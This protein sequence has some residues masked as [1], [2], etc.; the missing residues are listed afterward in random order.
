MATNFKRVIYIDEKVIKPK[1]KVGSA[2]ITGNASSAVPKRSSDQK[3][4][5]GRP[6]IYDLN[7]NLLASE[8]NLVVLTGREF[9]AQK[10]TGLQ[11]NNPTDLTQYRIS[12][13]GVGDS[14]VSPAGGVCDI[15]TVGPFDDDTDLVN[16]VQISAV[17]GA[18]PGKYIDN[19]M[20]KQ[21][22]SDGDIQVI[23]EEH[24]VNIP[25]GGQRVVDAYTA[26]RYRMYLQS[27]EPIDK[28]FCFNEAGLYAV[29]HVF[30]SV[31][32]WIPTENYILF[33]RFTTLDKWLDSGEGI[34]IEW[35]VLV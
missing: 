26:I 30:D 3:S 22:D 12:H 35:Y 4:I 20:L 27:G 21:I 9:I 29:E 23:S 31:L 16:R 10:L 2:V 28:P 7:G 32:G 5:I 33:A 19:G 6:N 17:S 14:G 8:E 13:F 25:T 1:D 15:T 34:M 18:N 11:G 24:T